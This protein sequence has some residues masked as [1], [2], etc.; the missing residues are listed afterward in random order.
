M[1][2]P[3]EICIL[4]YSCTCTNQGQTP[5]DSD[6]TVDAWKVSSSSLAPVLLVLHICPIGQVLKYQLPS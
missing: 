5:P 6:D 1:I 3:P 4:F 2:F